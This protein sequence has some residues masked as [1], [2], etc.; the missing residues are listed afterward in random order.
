M[1]HKRHNLFILFPAELSKVLGTEQPIHRYTR[2]THN[3]HT[4]SG[5]LLGGQ[6]NN[7]KNSSN[8]L[9]TGMPSLISCFP[10]RVT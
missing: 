8:H 5:Q 4:G 10:E 6:T 1:L 7:N 2:I 9:V 3:G